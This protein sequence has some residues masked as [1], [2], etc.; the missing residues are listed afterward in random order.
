MRGA[1]SAVLAVALAGTALLAAPAE[2]AGASPASVEAR[3]TA[4][5]RV[6]RCHGR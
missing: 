6:H 1:P 3:F 4:I 2:L 5:T